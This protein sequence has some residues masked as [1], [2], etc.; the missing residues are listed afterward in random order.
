[1]LALRRLLTPPRKRLRREPITDVII[2]ERLLIR[3]T[4]PGDSEQV[5]ASIGPDVEQINGWSSETKHHLAESIASDDDPWHWAIRLRDTDAFVGVLGAQFVD[6]LMIDGCEI[7]FW[8]ADDYRRNGYMTEAF[9]AF[10]DRLAVNEITQVRAT[11]ATSNIA[12]L[13]IMQTAGF[14]EIG[15]RPITLPNGTV[16]DGIDFALP[17]R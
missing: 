7:G 3:P 2:T 13:R 14:D 15:R 5:L 11:T 12:V 4:Q 6:P 1:M 10:V 9:R 8:V 16:M 17:A